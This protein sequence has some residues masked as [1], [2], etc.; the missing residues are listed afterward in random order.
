MQCARV[1]TSQ[2]SART[3][4]NNLNLNVL[5]NALAASDY[6]TKHNTGHARIA[7]AHLGGHE[8]HWEAQG[9]MIRNEMGTHGILIKEIQ[10]LAMHMVHK[11]SVV[12]LVLT[13]GLEKNLIHN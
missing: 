4:N 6:K 9:D 13:H 5:N 12:G 8:V 7:T 3:F 10:T 1:P 2:T 11:L